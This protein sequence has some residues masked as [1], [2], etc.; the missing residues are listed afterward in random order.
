MGLGGT[1]IRSVRE[2]TLT[3]DLVDRA[4]NELVWTGSAVYRPTAKERNDASQRINDAVARIFGR[5]PPTSKVAES[6]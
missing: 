2:D 3:V 6:R 4:K 5:F 1:D